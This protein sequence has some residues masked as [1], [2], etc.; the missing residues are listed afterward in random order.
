MSTHPFDQAIALQP[1]AEHE[2][3]GHTS[4]DYANFIGPYGGITAAQMVQAVMVHPQRLGE[5]VAFTINYAAALADGSFVARARP[6]R[7]NRST[8]HWIVE[9]L[10]DG[11][12]VATGTL[13]TAM[14]RPTWGLQEIAMPQVPRP[15]DLK[16][17]RARGVKWIENYERY[18]AEGGVP[19]EWNGQ[20][21]GHSRTR[22]WVR[23]RP[24]RPLDFPALAAIADNFFPRVWLRK[25]T[26]TA[27]GTVTMT[28]YFHA[29]SGV[30]QS[31][32]T[33]LLLAQAQGQAFRD[34]YFDQTGQL[35][36]EAG[37]LLVTT[38]QLVYYKE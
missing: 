5:P 14:R 24:P 19:S 7:T 30:L 27:I 1:L 29:D 28:V 37:E 9:L 11:Q 35:W 36:N 32:G 20:D 8:Q 6:A 10:Q 18:Y 31:T 34:G 21:A 22:L 4:P 15:A 2:W 25:A 23:D 3:Q 38:H 33:G 17:E 13:M 26:L 16:L 12:A